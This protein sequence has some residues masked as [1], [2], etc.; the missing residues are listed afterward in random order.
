[1]NK[2]LTM[3]ATIATDRQINT[4]YLSLIP[5][6]GGPIASG[7]TLYQNT[8]VAYLD[9]NVNDGAFV[10]AFNNP[11][12]VQIIANTFTWATSQFAVPILIN[13]IG[14]Y[15]QFPDGTQQTT[16]YT[17]SSNKTYSVEYTSTQSI[18]IPANCVGISVSLVGQGGQAG[19]N[20]DTGVGTTWNSG[21]S[22][23][24]ASMILS[25]TRI[26]ITSG[27]LSLTISN[28]SGNPNFLTYNAIEICRAYNGYNGGNATVGGGGVAGI[29]QTQG[30]GNT[31]VSTW[32]LVSGSV[33]T[34]GNANITFQNCAGVPTTAGKPNNILTTGTGNDT[35]RGC[36]QR[37][38][39]IGA[40]NQCPTSTPFQTSC[41]TV[42]YYL[43]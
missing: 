1:M 4:G 16:A 25:Q 9:N 14:N 12:G 11:V 33:G 3:N 30:L 18:T 41:L 36:G 13:N 7:T 19:F 10:M 37:Y 34:V 23:G 24:G 43:K 21:G 40:T 2:P 39:A 28:T 15:L 38:F 29:A 35:V 5:I 26:P 27:T 42:T 8:N 17:T 20:A 6:T 32:F 22:G 31:S